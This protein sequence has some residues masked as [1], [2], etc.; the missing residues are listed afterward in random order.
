MTYTS[1]FVYHA[2]K[3]TRTSSPFLSGFPMT[4]IRL[5]RSQNEFRSHL[6]RVHFVDRARSKE[7]ERCKVISETKHEATVRDAPEKDPLHFINTNDD[8]QEHYDR[9]R[10]QKQKEEEAKNKEAKAPQKR[11][12]GK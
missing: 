8:H 12:R 10:S 1:T 3:L 5:S 9:E 6:K 11:D 4:L 7:A 2:S